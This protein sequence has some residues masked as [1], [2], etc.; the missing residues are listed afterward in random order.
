MDLCFR[1][2]EASE[3]L[4]CSGSLGVILHTHTHTW[5]VHTQFLLKDECSKIQAYYEKV[6][7]SLAKEV[8]ATE[9]PLRIHR[10][11]HYGFPVFPDFKHTCCHIVQILNLPVGAVS[12]SLA[13]EWE[14]WRRTNQTLCRWYKMLTWMPYLTTEPS[15]NISYFLLRS[16]CL[17]A[18]QS[19]EPK[20]IIL[21]SFHSEDLSSLVEVVS[22]SDSKLLE[23][24]DGI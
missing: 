16:H 22:Y 3:S 15:M 11:N 21:H 2:S 19:T 24:S 18:A 7:I 8:Y 10:K 4:L 20:L 17:P 5:C 13:W 6:T 1:N 23:H 9:E 12:S 14:A